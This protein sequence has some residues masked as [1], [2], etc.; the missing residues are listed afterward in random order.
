MS[1]SE[2]IVRVLT[3]VCF[4]VTAASCS[5][6]DSAM[7]TSPSETTAMAAPPSRG[8]TILGTVKGGS[9]ATSRRFSA[10]TDSNMTV[11]VVGTNV[12]APVSISGS[13]LLENVPAGNLRLEFTATSGPA[14]VAV[15]GV[16]TGDR[17]DVQITISGSTGV[18]ESKIHIKANSSTVVEGE[19]ESVSGTCP[20]STIVVNDWKLQLDSTTRSA[21]A[22]IK[23]G[24]K[25]K[26]KGTLNSQKIIV[27]VRVEFSDR[28]DD[29]KDSDKDTDGDS[30]S[31][32]DSDRRRL[33]QRLLWL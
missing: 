9:S 7:P 25:V 27:V 18:L 6:T 11:T 33:I 14:T 24:V 16:E 26:I 30:D 4:A 10:L 28:R 8:A 31:D 3:I 15:P 32:S 21:C 23:V 22:T 12:S 29:D 17:L 13:F 2:R 20:N 19:V 5:G 1:F